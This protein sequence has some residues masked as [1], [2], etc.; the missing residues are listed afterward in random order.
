MASPLS[1]WPRRVAFLYV[2]LVFLVWILAL[3]TLP[4]SLGFE[5]LPYVVALPWSLLLL[6]SGSS[7]LFVV[8]LAGLLN[9]ALLYLVLGG[10]RRVG[11][12]RPRMPLLPPG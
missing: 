9:A 7:W 10:W 3:G 8:F 12:I 11:P 2:A 1:P 4:Y 5:L 6:H